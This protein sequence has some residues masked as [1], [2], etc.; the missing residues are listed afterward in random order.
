[1][2]SVSVK[3]ETVDTSEANI[4]RIILSLQ[5]HGLRGFYLE[6]RDVITVLFNEKQELERRL[7]E[8]FDGIRLRDEEVNAT[9][10]KLR[11]ELDNLKYQ[12]KVTAD[13]S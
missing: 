2:R 1:M 9:V 10:K 12:Q 13:G 4:N 8:A 6:L 5:N 3:Q 7:K 11:L